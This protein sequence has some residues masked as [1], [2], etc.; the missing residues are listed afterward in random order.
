V[1][2]QAMNR[3]TKAGNIIIKINSRKALNENKIEVYETIFE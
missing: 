2:Q 1:T 3:I